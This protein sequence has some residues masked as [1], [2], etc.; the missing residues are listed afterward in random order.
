L[1]I[2]QGGLVADQ[3]CNSTNHAIT[4]RDVCDN[5]L[6]VYHSVLD[7]SGTEYLLKAR[8]RAKNKI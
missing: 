2:I 1:S 6:Y 7:Y 3:L 4:V 8:T 5:N